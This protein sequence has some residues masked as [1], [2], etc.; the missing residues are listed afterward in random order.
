MSSIDRSIVCRATSSRPSV[1]RRRQPVL[2]T[3][4]FVGV[5]TSDGVVEITH[6]DD[7]PDYWAGVDEQPD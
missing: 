3:G 1:V 2:R 5:L 7:D 6:Y 4:R